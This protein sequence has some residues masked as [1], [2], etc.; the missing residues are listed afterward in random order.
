MSSKNWV[1]CGNSLTAVKN[2]V[3]EI[4]SV[5]QLNIMKLCQ[6]STYQLNIPLAEKAVKNNQ[7]L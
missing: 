7:E 3:S 4:S 1:V 2:K 6:V 5:G